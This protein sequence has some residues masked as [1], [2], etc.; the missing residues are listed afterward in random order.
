MNPG[1]D[2]KFPFLMDV[3]NVDLTGGK[4]EACRYCTNSILV[5][6]FLMITAKDGF[7]YVAFTLVYC[8]LSCSSCSVNME[9]ILSLS[10]RL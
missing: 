6:F 9:S 10:I 3:A 2:L 5:Y 1:H 7:L 8:K 4:Y